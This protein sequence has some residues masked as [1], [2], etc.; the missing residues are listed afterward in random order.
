MNRVHH[1]QNRAN[2]MRKNKCRESPLGIYLGLLNHAKPRKLKLIEKCHD[3]GISM[4]YQR[5]MD[6][7]TEMGNKVLN[8]Y[9]EQNLGCHPSLKLNLFTN[10]A[11]II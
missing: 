1:N 6:L 5:V 7:S 9:E 10:S 4:S 2:K 8:H 11:L 3:L